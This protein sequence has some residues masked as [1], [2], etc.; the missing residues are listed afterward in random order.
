M[1]KSGIERKN[2][3]LTAFTESEKNKAYLLFI[4][5]VSA[6]SIV[7]Y[8][9]EEIDNLLND[10]TAFERTAML[11]MQGCTKADCN[12]PFGERRT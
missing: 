11:A 2:W 12:K 1:I 6:L 10:K 5:K 9:E 3:E 7:G 8:S 4:E